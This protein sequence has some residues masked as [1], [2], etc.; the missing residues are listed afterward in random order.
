VAVKNGARVVW[1]RKKMKSAH[2]FFKKTRGGSDFFDH[3][4]SNDEKSGIFFVI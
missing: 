2:A 3:V 4:T 1:E